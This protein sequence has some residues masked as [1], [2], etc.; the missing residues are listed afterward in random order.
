MGQSKATESKLQKHLLSKQSNDS[1]AT[2]GDMPFTA[3]GK[4][5][6]SSKNRKELMDASKGNKT[7]KP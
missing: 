6:K 2:Y 4:G 3:I 5:K 1:V 7:L